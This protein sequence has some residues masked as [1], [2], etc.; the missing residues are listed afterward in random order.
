ML[1]LKI[2]NMNLD[3]SHLILADAQKKTPDLLLQNS[4]FIYCSSLH[5]TFQILNFKRNGAFLQKRKNAFF[6][7]KRCSQ[8]IGVNIKYS[9]TIHRRASFS[10]F[11]ITPN[12]ISKSGRD[13]LM[14]QE[15]FDNLILKV[16]Q[17]F[18]RRKNP[19][20]A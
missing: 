4:G 10:R 3:F 8:Q 18:F 5:E 14:D 6:F 2:S 1:Y 9:T 16:H 19:I 11:F 15:K 12:S 17:K 7:I 20:M 13:L